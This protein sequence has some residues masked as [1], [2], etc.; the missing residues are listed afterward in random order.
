MGR[1][2]Q[3]LSFSLPWSLAQ[4]FRAQRQIPPQGPVHMLRAQCMDTHQMPMEAWMELIVEDEGCP[5]RRLPLQEV[6][7]TGG[8]PYRT[9]A[10][11]VIPRSGQLEGKVGITEIKN[12]HTLN[13]FLDT[14]Y[15]V[16][17]NQ[18]PLSI[19]CCIWIGLCQGQWLDRK[20]FYLNVK[21]H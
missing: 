14:N 13:C 6:G 5:Y 19:R 8:W 2:L 21:F 9:L 18:L 3:E 12:L 4:L 15:T 1:Q 11:L 20:I 17:R 7:P 16:S 10:W